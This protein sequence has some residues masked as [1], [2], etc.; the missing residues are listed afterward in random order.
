MKLCT[1]RNVMPRAVLSGL[2]LATAGAQTFANPIIGRGADPSVILNHGVYYSVQSG[3]AHQGNTPVICIRSAP[4]LPEL[5]RAVPVVIWTAPASGPNSADIW[6]PQIDFFGGEFHVYYAAGSVAGL[7]DHKLFALVPGTTGE[8]LRPWI[9]AS[10][11]A[12]GGELVTN[13]KSVWG[14]DPDVFLASDHKY[15]LLYACRQDNT[16]SRS[17]KEQSICLSEMSDPLHLTGQTVALSNPTQPWETRTFPT[18]EGPFGFVHDGV[19]YI[20]YSASFSGT[21]DDYSEALLINNH[22]P[23][24]NGAGNPL[25]NPASWIKEGP[26]FDGHH[27]SYGTA[28]NVIVPSPDGT[29][30]WNVYHGTDCLNNCPMVNR[31]TWRDRSVRAQKAGWSHVGSLVMGY[32]VDINNLLDHT[33]GD[34]PLA[35]PSANGRGTLTV[36]AWGAA[37]GDAAEGD[38]ADGQPVGTWN[39]LGP[40]AIS[41]T[42]LDP[43]HF[44]RIFFGANPNWQDYVLYTKIKRV[45]TGTGNS[46]PRYG[47]YGAYVDHKNYFVAMIDVTSCGSPGCVTTDAVIEGADKGW[48]NCALPADFDAQAANT[49]V[50]EA[51]NGM[52]TVW[53]NGKMLSGECQAR[54]FT[55]S[56]GQSPL[57]GSN[58]QAGVIVE[59]TKAEYTSFGVSPGVPVD[60]RTYALRNGASRMNLSTAC[61][62][63][64][65]PAVDGAAVLQFPAFAPYPVV[66]SA[67]QLWTLHD[68]HD[69]YFEI[70]STKS[71]MCLEDPFG[72]TAPS[73][74]L[75]QTPGTSTMLW[76]HACNGAGSQLWQFIPVPDGSSFVLQNK[77]SL[78]VLDSYK[79]SQGTL[80]WLNTRADTPA[81]KWHLIVQ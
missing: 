2:F 19:D 26:V 13:W 63:C 3:C 62:E 81:Q 69:G 17:S 11:G 80:M 35:F 53:V 12:P 52:F 20:L 16:G 50:V 1:T 24:P 68:R 47:V 23:Q 42:G 36:P 10:T 34:V 15:Y 76:Q 54:Q 51:A 61:N 38:T 49:L 78:L 22:P 74:T 25:T 75:P 14:I 71:G 57:H 40:A 46:H 9:V 4:T 7:N 41:S 21:A 6:A 27:A 59:N 28:S 56:A 37:F 67:T 79:T 5:G 43:D 72:N 65:S 30:L 73:R 64:A 60:G 8:P 33:G 70:A 29:E 58:G 77:A 44:D 66:T 32:P 31:K 39:S 45:A 18:Q 55:L 48:Q